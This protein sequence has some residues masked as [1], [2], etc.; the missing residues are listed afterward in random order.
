M[1]LP[2]S[3]H[4]DAAS[5]SPFFN[6]DTAPTFRVVRAML[7]LAT[8]YDVEH[9]RAEALRRL[10]LRCYTTLAGYD[11]MLARFKERQPTRYV[12]LDPSD[13]I[14]LVE[15]LP[16]AYL[17]LLIGDPGAL[18]NRVDYG[19]GDFEELSPLDLRQCLH[20][21]K[22][23]TDMI[24]RKLDLLMKF[25]A[26]DDCFYESKHCHEQLTIAFSAIDSKYHFSLNSLL[27]PWDY[28]VGGA[29]GGI[30]PPCRDKWIAQ[31]NGFRENMWT[32]LGEIIG[33]QP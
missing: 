23:I 12:V 2:Y 15:L 28:R 3:S 4:I 31:Y 26:S 13:P 30:C 14:G 5:P 33:I 18:M 22:R 24:P 25:E 6:P 7:I 32:S 19:F 9:V 27:A 16:W 1:L 17:R 21:I 8:K 29:L 20:G 11:A 10:H